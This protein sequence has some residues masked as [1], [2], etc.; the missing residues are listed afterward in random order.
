M[1]ISW[2]IIY[3]YILYIYIYYIYIYYI[4][5]CTYIIQRKSS[6][7]ILNISYKRCARRAPRTARRPLRRPLRRRWRIG[8]GMRYID[9][10]NGMTWLGCADGVGISQIIQNLSKLGYFSIDTMVSGIP[11]YKNPPI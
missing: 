6:Q 3:I 9:G 2:Y 10:A 4:Y 5:I 1:D 8:Y 7:Q 11:H